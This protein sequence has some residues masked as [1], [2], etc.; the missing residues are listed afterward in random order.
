M[1][2]VVGIYF[3]FEKVSIIGASLPFLTSLQGIGEL[4]S[5]IYFIRPYRIF[6][7]RSLKRFLPQKNISRVFRLNPMPPIVA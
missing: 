5:I 7:L 4:F 1:L 2:F 3:G 6:I